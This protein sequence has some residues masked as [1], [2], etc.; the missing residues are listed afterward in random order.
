MKANPQVTIAIPSYNQAAYL[1]QALDSVLSQSIPLEIFVMD[2]G[3]TDNS[4]AVIKRFESHL[5]GFRSHADAGQSAAINEGIAKGTAPYVCW[6]NS[7]DWLLPD[8]LNR[9]LAKLKV[10]PE[11]PAVYG[12]ALNFIEKN[13]RYTNVWVEPFNQHRL[14][15]RCIISQPATLI[16]REAWDS[17][18]GVN[19]CLH[20]AM[21]YHL[22][23]S[24]FNTFGPLVWLDETVAVNRIHPYT[25]T[26]TQ[27]RLHYKEAMHIV[28][29]H[30]GRV[31]IKWWLY[32]PY[33]VWYKSILSLCTT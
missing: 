33:A 7:D 32:Q 17:I 23:W 31:P 1:E 21:D 19:E 6:L 20:M 15:K 12:N 24:L 11:A 18:G 3:S 5:S 14:A 2:G 8:A 10:H 25:K 30:Y 29:T 13:K 28:K 16:R 4:L 22:W 27:R 9:L 26:R